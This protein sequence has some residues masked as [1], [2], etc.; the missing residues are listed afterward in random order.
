[1]KTKFKNLLSAIEKRQAE[2][3]GKDMPPAVG[4]EIDAMATEAM[5]LQNLIDAEQKRNDRLAG[6]RDFGG[7]IADP[8]MPPE[9]QPDQ[10][11]DE[12]VV[13]YISTGDLVAASKGLRDFLAA[14]KPKTAFTL[15]SIPSPLKKRTRGNFVPLT[16]AQLAELKQSSP[17]IGANVLMPEMLT[18][19][20]R[21]FEHDKLTIRDVLSVGTTT[22]NAVRYLRQIY[23]RGAA[24]VAQGVAKPDSSIE[25]DSQLAAVRK[26]AVW[27]PVDDEQ[28]ADFAEL[29]R[30]INEE[31]L[32]DLAKHLEELVCYGSGAGEEFEGIFNDT[33]VPSCRTVADDTLIDKARRMITDV[34]IAGYQPNG[35][36]VHPIDWESIVLAKGEDLRYIWT[37][38]TDGATQRL[39]GVP[40]IESVATQDY[41]G[42]ATEERN[43]L[44]GDFLRGAT[45][46]DREQAN[47]SVGWINDQFIENKRTILAELRA[48]FAVRRPKAFC[49]FMT[50]AAVQS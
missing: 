42:N 13:G 28:L 8:A 4:A 14:G 20:V 21:P 29:A 26:I 43:M 31:E 34:V 25:F 30:I 10:K 1:M 47:I 2:Y 39:W 11:N 9:S 36:L 27:M 19:I 33:D 50:Q 37:I 32:Y 23:T 15:A 45:L 24:A 16:G 22:A 3:A 5:E 6:L 40:V 41:Q 17:T 18:D 48:A 44:V 49:K 46:W 38:V 35:I 7:R 12:K